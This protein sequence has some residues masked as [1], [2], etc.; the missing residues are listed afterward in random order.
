MSNAS[1][2]LS[3]VHL[4]L[5]DAIKAYVTSK[6]ERLLRHN[7]RILR[8]DFELE[9]GGSRDHAAD[10]SAGAQIVIAGPDIVAKVESD[11]LYKSVDLLIDKLDRALRRRHRY[12]KV[13]RHLGGGFRDAA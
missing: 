11:D 12:D 3:G 4:E 1:I 13:K 10:F 9:R 7:P 8:I 5:T 2:V 6:A